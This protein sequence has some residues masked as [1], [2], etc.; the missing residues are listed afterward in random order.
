[1]EK[2]R[3]AIR[4]YLLQDGSS[5][6]IASAK[7]RITKLVNES[8]ADLGVQ[9]ARE[10]AR[11][12]LA[13]VI[14]EGQNISTGRENLLK[15]R[16][17]VRS[18]YLEGD[19]VFGWYDPETQVQAEELPLYFND[20]AYYYYVSFYRRSDDYSFWRSRGFEAAED[21]PTIQ[22]RDGLEVKFDVKRSLFWLQ[23]G[24]ALPCK[25]Q[26]HRGRF[27]GN[28]IGDDREECFWV[29]RSIISSG[30]WC[31]YKWWPDCQWWYYERH[32]EW[33]TEM[34]WWGTPEPV[35]HEPI[36]DPY[37]AVLGGMG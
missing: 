36:D 33:F 29:S 27:D 28:G 18:F 10:L 19:R 7:G 2:L 8:A 20:G 22:H 12:V 21:L 26:Y 1:M 37:A 31:A 14:V 17:D 11:T 32:P 3:E 13:L 34:D 15:N 5:R 35:R 30:W 4:S 16:F 23:Y 9:K 25:L 24:Y 6:K